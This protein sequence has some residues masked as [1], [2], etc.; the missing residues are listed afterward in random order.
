MGNEIAYSQSDGVMKFEDILT[1][2]TVSLHIQF[3]T[4]SRQHPSQ[5]GK[6]DFSDSSNKSNLSLNNTEVMKKHFHTLYLLEIQTSMAPHIGWS[7]SF[8]VNKPKFHAHSATACCQCTVCFLSSLNQLWNHTT[9]LSCL[10]TW[11]L[12]CWK[13]GN[14]FLPSHMT[15]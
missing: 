1:R 15:S 12:K 14:L 11:T 8:K 6:S 9:I 10:M 13:R 5:P 4:S 7:P 3:P 2:V